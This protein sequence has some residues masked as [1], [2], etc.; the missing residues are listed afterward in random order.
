MQPC[1]TVLRRLA[2]GRRI[3]RHVIGPHRPIAARL[4]RPFSVPVACRKLGPL[5]GAGGLGLGAGGSAGPGQTG[6]QGGQ[7]GA[8]TGSGGAGGG[9]A[10]GG[11]A[12]SGG[13]TGG[14]RSST[15][16]LTQFLP[17]TL[18]IET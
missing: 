9:G 4:R 15:G 6:G 18:S 5:L 17:Q 7:S 16:P 12:G 8:S 10:G 13:E 11:G 3:Y 2:P 1:W 14:T